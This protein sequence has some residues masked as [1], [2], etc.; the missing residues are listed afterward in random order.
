M[1]EQRSREASEDAV[2]PQPPEEIRKDKRNRKAKDE[3][4]SYSLELLVMLEADRPALCS[5]P[6]GAVGIARG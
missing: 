2:P 3:F 4:K 6:E 1:S 5:A